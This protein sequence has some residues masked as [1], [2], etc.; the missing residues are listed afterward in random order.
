MIE[1]QMDGWRLS[2]YNTFYSI[3]WTLTTALAKILSSTSST[4]FEVSNKT[5]LFGKKCSPSNDTEWRDSFNNCSLNGLHVASEAIGISFGNSTSECDV[6]FFLF[7]FDANAIAMDCLTG[8][9][10]CELL[11][12]LLNLLGDVASTSVVAVLFLILNVF[13][14]RKSFNFCLI[15][16]R[17]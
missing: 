15:E 5:S 17:L 12:I 8:R 14:E 11:S 2:L 4:M 1:G 7:N 16:R 9:L 10:L 3:K 13:T 6:V